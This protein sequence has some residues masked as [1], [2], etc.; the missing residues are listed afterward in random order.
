M[1]R[2]LK[3][4]AK[5]LIVVGVLAVILASFA[6]LAVDVA[7]D[8]P[9]ALQTRLAARLGTPVK[10][11]SVSLSWHNLRPELVLHGLML[12]AGQAQET[13]PKTAKARAK[14]PVKVPVKAGALRVGIN[15][16]SLLQGEL[17]PAQLTLV[18]VKLDLQVDAGGHVHIPAFGSTETDS[19]HAAQQFLQQLHALRLRRCVVGIRSPY[20]GAGRKQ[21][22]LNGE[23]TRALI[24]GAPVYHLQLRLEPPSAIAGRVILHMQLQGRPLFKAGGGHNWSAQWTAA[25]HGLRQIPW[26]DQQFGDG[27]SLHLDSGELQLAGRF[28]AGKP[29]T[30]RGHLAVPQLSVN[31][32][33]RR[34]AG[35]RD[36]SATVAWQRVA[37]GWQLQLEHLAAF[38]SG[39]AHASLS[40][41]ARIDWHPQAWSLHASAPSLALPAL[42]RWLRLWPGLGA[43]LPSQSGQLKLASLR[44]QAKD[45]KIKLRSNAVNAGKDAAAS[46]DYQLSGK[47]VQLGW[48][49]YGKLPGVTG[50]SGDFEFDTAGGQLHIDAAPT[51]RVPEFFFA[52]IKLDTLTT[53]VRWHKR[54][55]GGWQVTAAP[56]QL[57]TLGGQATGQLQLLLSAEAGGDGPKMKLNLQ[58]S[59]ADAARLKPLMPRAWSKDLRAWLSQALIH[60]PV[61]KGHLVI[62]GSLDD[63]PYADAGT[64]EHWT[65]DLQVAGATLRFDPAWPAVRDLDGKLHFSRRAMDIDVASARLGPVKVHGAEA[66]I[67]DFD[68]DDL[69]VTAHAGADIKDW[70]TLLRASPLRGSLSALLQQSSASGPAEVQLRLD[71]PPQH[72]AQTKATGTV[73][74]QAVRYDY[75]PL[76]MPIKAV[77]GTL[78]FDN[79]GLTDLRLRGQVDHT[80]LQAWLQPSGP[81][82]GQAGAQSNGGQPPARRAVVEVR[83]P[84]DPS[85]DAL[86]A[87]YLPQWLR[88]RLQGTSTWRLQL[89]LGNDAHWV[90]RSQLRDTAIHLPAPLAKPLGTALPVTVRPIVATAGSNGGLRIDGGSRFGMQLRYNQDGKSVAG[91]GL[92]LG[93]GAPVDA[94]GDGV[95]LGGTVGE[96]DI[97]KSLALLSG[98]QA[99]SDSA[100]DSRAAVAALPFLGGRLDVAEL[101]WHELQVSQ[102]RLQLDPE[103]DNTRIVVRGNN[104]HGDI[105]WNPAAAAVTA[106]FSRLH[107]DRLQTHDMSGSAPAPA[108]APLDPRQLPTVDVHCRALSV[109]NYALGTLVLRTHHTPGGQAIAAAKLS[110]AEVGM[111]ADGDWTRIGGVSS[112]RLGFAVQAKKFEDALHAFGFTRSVTAKQAN[113]RGSVQIPPAHNGLQLANLRGKIS[114]ELDDGQLKAVHPGAGRVFGLLNIYALPRR[115]LRKFKGVTAKGLV[116]DK[117]AANFKLGNGQAWTKDAHISGPAVNVDIRGRI[118]LQAHDLDETVRVYPKIASGITVGAALLG[119]PVVGGI[120]LLAQQLF[121]TALSHLSQLRYRVTGSWDNP[122][123]ERV[124]TDAEAAAAAAKPPVS[125]ASAASA[126]AAT[127]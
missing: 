29:A 77:Q 37:D 18:G 61:K 75:K 106:R 32:Q 49:P 1:S 26:L 81:T 11:A 27:K 82:D 123:V 28:A 35:L 112:A 8:L 121:G 102:V 59:G 4:I 55:R 5:T 24:D 44:G 47:L 64:D 89:P 13:A 53:T 86:A 109:G 114:V 88:T 97:G 111:G 90:L 71:I 98:L 110:G 105:L 36:L 117:L 101:R 41:H 124:D 76:G 126:A 58:L 70:Y 92:R 65:L 67:A 84:V 72:T 122:T 68:T 21:F 15:Y 100:A 57:S 34:L 56:L 40:A 14:V 66:K 107:F 85:R 2:W 104:A 52:P 108:A 96:L 6:T 23:A 20:L 30:A 38:G 10:I 63:F 69:V 31:R 7:P 51:L 73:H 113:F 83:F 116:F 118:G 9:G 48:P 33:G 79:D 60:A 91:V 103:G 54:K 19:G 93:A 95:R 3:T 22:T 62:D 16:R 125:A 78:S 99:E 45:I 17:R 39:Q 87:R 74:L 42:A 43:A 46:L 80:P 12:G 94:S 115:L 127:H 120:A 25:V 119:G 50:L